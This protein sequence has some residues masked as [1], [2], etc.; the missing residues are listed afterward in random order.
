MRSVSV[1]NVC[2][3]SIVGGDMQSVCGLAARG[4]RVTHTSVCAGN[5]SRILH[6]VGGG[7]WVVGARGG[8]T[9]ILIIP[10]NFLS[11]FLK[12]CLGVKKI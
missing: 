1:R 2:G 6:V 4:G 3:E 5:L 10:D 8:N 11:L 9:N 7:L 12:I